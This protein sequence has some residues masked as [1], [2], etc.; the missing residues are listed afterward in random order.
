MLNEKP[1]VF[2][3]RDGVLNEEIGYIRKVEDLRIF[4]YVAE[5]I[6]KIKKRG[7]LTIVISNQS[8]IA[9]GLLEEKDLL[10]MNDYL[11]KETDIDAVYYCPH[12]PLGIIEQY[13]KICR[14]RKPGIGLI[15]Q[16][17]KEF[18]IDMAYSFMV[19]DRASDIL[20]GKNAGLKT[21]L[22]ESG[23]GTLRLESDVKPDYIKMDLRGILEII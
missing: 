14:C 23:Y 18:Q 9:R 15:E 10:I 12:H 21:V 8:G 2:L 17:Q 13:K 1:V 20:M 5:C 16:A 7:Y 4:P 19:G 3:D 6:Q 22:L 11:K